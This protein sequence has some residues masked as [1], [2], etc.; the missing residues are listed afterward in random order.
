MFLPLNR[1]QISR[2]DE[3]TGMNNYNKRENSESRKFWLYDQGECVMKLV[4]LKK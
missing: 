1:C 2:R 3:K 4:A